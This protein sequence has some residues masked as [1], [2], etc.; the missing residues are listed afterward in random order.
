MTYDRKADP[1]KARAHAKEVLA[2]AGVLKAPVQ[3]ERVIKKLNIV[4]RHEALDEELSGMAYIN[5]GLSIIGINAIHHPNRQRFSAAHELGHHILH[6]EEITGAVHVD[7]GEFK[8]LFRNESSSLGADRLEIE[9]NAIASELLVPEELL[10]AEMGGAPV[11]VANDEQVE[12][13]AKKFRV[14]VQAMR[15]R[16]LGLL[17]EQL[18]A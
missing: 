1:Q 3:V 5:D 8:V 4:L 6:A 14:S 15:I 10:L 16:L 12:E 11:D 2:K 9:A 17:S 13:L 7:K 18:S